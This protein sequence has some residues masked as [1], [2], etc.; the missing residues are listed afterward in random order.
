[1]DVHKLK[2]KMGEFPRWKSNPSLGRSIEARKSKG[3][4]VSKGMILC[5]VLKHFRQHVKVTIIP[6]PNIVND[7][8]L[9]LS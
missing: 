8:E 5:L 3:Y 7:N 2:N 9:D 6:P 4:F 1:M